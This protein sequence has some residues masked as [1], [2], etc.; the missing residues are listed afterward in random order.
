MR[1]V[2]VALCLITAAC[3]ARSTLRTGQDRGAGGTTNGPSTGP[4]GPGAGGMAG[5]PEFYCMPDIAEGARGFNS[6]FGSSVR[7]ARLS[8]D[9]E[10]LYATLAHVEISD[11][12]GDTPVVGQI[13]F[14]AW[15][16]DWDEDELLGP[17]VPVLDGSVNG[18]ATSSSVEDHYGMVVGNTGGFVSFIHH[19]ADLETYPPATTFA[20]SAPRPLFMT[21]FEPRLVGIAEGVDPA[22]ERLRL[23]RGDTSGLIETV[24]PPS[25]T[26]SPAFADGI[27][28]GDDGYLVVAAVG[29]AGGSDCTTDQPATRIQVMHVDADVSTVTDGFSSELSEPIRRLEMSRHIDGAWVVWQTAT[30]VAPPIVAARINLN[31]EVIVPPEVLLPDG[32]VR[33]EWTVSSNFTHLLLAHTDT[34]LPG[35]PT[36]VISAFNPE[37]E[38]VRDVLYSSPMQIIGSYRLLSAFYEDMM[39]LA[40]STLDSPTEL[41]TSRMFV[42]RF[43]CNESVE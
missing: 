11:I 20:A 14:D 40:F 34:S 8:G 24:G 3:G 1:F 16:P 33:E 17:A 9:A 41:G 12:I 15:G 18:L 10:E 43:Y 38:F 29:S 19:A 2:P 23:L 39:L 21:E 26:R 27:T 25:C 42:E 31:G 5:A 13:T 7:E 28:H 35:G 37:A 22:H 6:A 36:I 4:S 32:V 30:G